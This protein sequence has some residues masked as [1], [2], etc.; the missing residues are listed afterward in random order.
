MK[1]GMSLQ[2]RVLEK[3]VRLETAQNLKRDLAAL[4]EKATL[5]IEADKKSRYVNRQG[6][7][8]LH[9][10]ASKFSIRTGW[11]EREPDKI[12]IY[13]T[14]SP[15]WHDNC[16]AFFVVFWIFRSKLKYSFDLNI[17]S[18]IKNWRGQIKNKP[19][20][21][22]KWKEEDQGRRHLGLG[23]HRCSQKAPNRRS[24]SDK[25][26]QK[27]I[28]WQRVNQLNQPI[29]SWPRR[30]WRRLFIRKWRWTHTDQSQVL[31]SI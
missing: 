15:P 5:S 11:V 6:L 22:K 10:W 14:S 3:K 24:S 18:T 28:C 19:Y 17:K 8:F 30:L 12:F 20:F 4:K 7:F 9:L 16:N 29:W 31:D 13:M 27:E 2:K 26:Q 21:K 1:H 23:S 25:V